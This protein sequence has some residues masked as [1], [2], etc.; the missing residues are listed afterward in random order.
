MMDLQDHVGPRQDEQIVVAAQIVRVV[1]EALAAEVGFG[2]LDAAGSSSPS[3][4]RG[5]GFAD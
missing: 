3:R 5:R 4:R 1:R 2:Q